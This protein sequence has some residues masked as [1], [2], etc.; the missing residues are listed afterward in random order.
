MQ[1][2]LFI[3]LIKNTSHLWTK[4]KAQ[5]VLFPL[6]EIASQFIHLVFYKKNVELLASCSDGSEVIK[7]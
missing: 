3:V 4:L 7:N 6:T 1:Q 5:L 2:F